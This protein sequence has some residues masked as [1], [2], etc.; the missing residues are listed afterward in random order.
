MI[1]LYPFLFVV[2]GLLTC[3]QVSQAKA[4]PKPQRP[5]N[6]YINDL[7]D[8]IEF[9][10]DGVPHKITNGKDG[11]VG[12]AGHNGGAGPAG[13]K[14]D[15]GPVGPSGRYVDKVQICHVDWDGSPA[16]AIDYL[17]FVYSDQIKESFASV[18]TD[19][20]E[21]EVNSAIWIKDDARYE[22]APLDIGGFAF[23][24]TGTSAVVLY[25]STGR[26]SDLVCH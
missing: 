16:Y 24:Q 23:T 10:C 9:V 7:P 13:P 8:G 21:I 15:Q 18:Q 17:V 19:K 2:F 3:H 11:A 25:R 26:T 22:Q 6:C 12:P 5:E 1:K 14:G 4:K 20:G